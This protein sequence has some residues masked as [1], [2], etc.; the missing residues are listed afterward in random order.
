M[1]YRL[2]IITKN[3]R[4]STLFVNNRY[5]KLHLKFLTVSACLQPNIKTGRDILSGWFDLKFELSHCLY[6]FKFFCSLKPQLDCFNAFYHFI[7]TICVSKKKSLCVHCFHTQSAAL[8]RTCWFHMSMSCYIHS[9]FSTS[10]VKVHGS[11]DLKW[12][13]SVR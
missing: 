6:S 1:N 7:Q 5:V 9:W 13:L 10:V 11:C 2:L 12:K 3:F 8:L 4:L